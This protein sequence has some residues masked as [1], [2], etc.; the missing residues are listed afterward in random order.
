MV[1]PARSWGLSCLGSWSACFSGITSFMSPDRL[2]SSGGASSWVARFLRRKRTES[3]NS[4][5]DSVTRIHLFEQIQTYENKLD[6]LEKEDCS[7]SPTMA[8]EMKE[9]RLKLSQY[10]RLCA[11]FDGNRR[12][13]DKLWEYPPHLF[14]H[15]A[16]REAPIRENEHK[17]ARMCVHVY[18][19]REHTGVLVDVT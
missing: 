11:K 14:I 8:S 2:S 18:R 5:E 9:T 3:V 16:S 1:V 15:A 19:R 4:I 17:H 7:T 13:G 6:E 10:T 12:T